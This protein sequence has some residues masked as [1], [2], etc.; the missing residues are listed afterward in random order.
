MDDIDR[1]Q[2]REQQL[3]E[4]ALAEHMHLAQRSHLIPC[5]ECYWC[6]EPVSHGRI[7]CDFGCRDDWERDLAAR[8]R[9]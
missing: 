3:R 4:D 1:A 6:S 2:E 5:G 9:A 8:K 7:F